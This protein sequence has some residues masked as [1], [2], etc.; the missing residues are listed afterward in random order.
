VEGEWEDRW[1]EKRKLFGL[2]C[3]GIEGQ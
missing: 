1:G 3:G 2:G